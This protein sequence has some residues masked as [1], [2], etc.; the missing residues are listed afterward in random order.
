MIHNDCSI[1][2]SNDEYC[3]IQVKE[4]NILTTIILGYFPPNSATCFEDVMRSVNPYS[5]V[6]LMGD[7]NSRIGIFNN[8]VSKYNRHSKDSTINK[9]GKS[10]I[11]YLM[12]TDLIVLNGCTKSDQNGDL[13]FINKNGSSVIDLCIV[14]NSITA[15]DIDFRVLDDN[16]SCHFPIFSSKYSVNPSNHHYIK[17]VCWNPNK[18]SQ[19][20]DCLENL[21][22][23]HNNTAISLTE[24]NKLIIQSL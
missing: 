18:S 1:I 17:R 22:N 4:N 12:T 3:V 15:N 21:L 11:N 8:T 16:G 9:R 2:E 7:L 19:F 10:L 20:Q 13:T 5:Q 6:I 24:F 23:Q 14:S